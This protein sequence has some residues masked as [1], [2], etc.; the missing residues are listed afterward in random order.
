MPGDKLRSDGRALPGLVGKLDVGGATRLVSGVGE[1]P[2][3]REGL[4]S[5]AELLIEDARE[6][7]GQPRGLF[8][9]AFDLDEL[10]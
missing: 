3:R 2:E 6:L 10:A 5:L 4:I 7:D 8:F 9:V 1:R